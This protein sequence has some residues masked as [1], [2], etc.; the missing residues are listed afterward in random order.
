MTLIELVVGLV[1]TGFVVMVGYAAFGTVIDRREQ[2]ARSAAETARVTGIRRTLLRWLDGAQ[3]INY[4]STDPGATP[5]LNVV[6]GAIT[7]MRAPVAR[8]QLR[9]D[10]G[11][12]GM[13]RGLVAIFRPDMG[14]DSL[15]VM[16][17]SMAQ[18]LTISYL[19]SSSGTREWV[20][21][22][23]PLTMQP[24]AVRLQITSADPQMAAAFALP[25]DVP[26]N[27]R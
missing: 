19:I 23:A 12:T 7:P 9:I 5:Q 14:G 6:T 20:T 2:V 21:S 24:A 8:L 26:I 13:G 10:D 4:R 11:S 3:L 17:D 16:L 1:V 25:L 27:P 15:R 22:D 18:S